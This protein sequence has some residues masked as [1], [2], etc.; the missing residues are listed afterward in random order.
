MTV[1]SELRNRGAEDVCIVACDGLKGLPEAVTAT[2]PKATVQTCVIHRSRQETTWWLSAPT[3]VSRSA[4]V[5]WRWSAGVMSMWRAS[6]IGRTSRIAFHSVLRQTPNSW[7]R[8]SRPQTRR[9]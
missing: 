8:E 9:R 4:A 6:R 2:W 3:E 5:G 7:A 1:L